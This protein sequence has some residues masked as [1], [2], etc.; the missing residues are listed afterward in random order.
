MPGSVNVHAPLLHLTRCDDDDDDDDDIFYCVWVVAM[1]TTISNTAFRFKN[2]T[3]SLSNTSK[4]Y[5][6]IACI[7]QTENPFPISQQS[8]YDV[9]EKYR[10]SRYIKSNVSD[11]EIAGG[12]ALYVD[13]R[14]HTRSS[15]TRKLQLLPLYCLPMTSL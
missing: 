8:I 5:Y 9:E 3:K 14:T 10:A 6:L 12:D 1:P 13:I 11:S 2:A 15:L 4:L 7:I